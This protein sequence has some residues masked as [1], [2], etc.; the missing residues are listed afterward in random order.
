MMAV[1]I[2][3]PLLTL[4]GLAE[5]IF[6]ILVTLRAAFRPRQLQLHWHLCLAAGAARIQVKVPEEPQRRY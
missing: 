6:G 4:Q 5:H 2:S 1:S 3:L